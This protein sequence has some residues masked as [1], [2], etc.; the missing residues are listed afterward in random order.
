MKIDEGFLNQI[1]KKNC[2]DGMKV[3]PDD[4]V[5]LIV[6]DPP[7]NLSKSKKL[8]MRN[9]D[10]LEGFG[11]DW[12]ITDENWDKMTLDEYVQ[13]TKEWVA[14]CKRI[15]KP[16]GSIWVFGSYHNIGLVNYV[17]QELDIEI[18]NE[19]IWYKRNAFPNLT[20][21]R[22]TASHESI[23][24]GHKGNEKNRKYYFNYEASRDNDYPEDGLKKQGKQ[25]RSV[26]DIPNNKKKDELKHGKHPTQ[27]PERI[28]KRMI[29]LTSKE[30]DL[31]LDPFMGSGATAVVSKL[32][33]RDYIGFELDEK[34][35]DLANKKISDIA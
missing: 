25:M 17:F 34:Y 12:D 13:F 30:G 4:S 11:G 2:I 7:Y 23:L 1:Y 5:D 21:R 35:I 16:T 10:K 20:G 18:L 6:A 8:K 14:E 33:G 26:W 31:V 24:W 15:L 19:I 22:F 32:L 9:T 29:E 28:L 27:K 3:L